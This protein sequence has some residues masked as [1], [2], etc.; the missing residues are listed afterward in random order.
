MAAKEELLEKLRQEKEQPRA[1]AKD[2][3]AEW[4]EAIAQLFSQLYKWLADPEAKH[5]LMVF[6]SS[7]TVREEDLLGEYDAPAFKIN[8][9]NGEAVYVVP[10]ARMV[11]GA[12]G[13]VDLECMPRRLT[14][15]R[16]EPTR[17]KLGRLPRDGGGWTFQDLTES[18]FWE[19]LSELL[20]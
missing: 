13:R 18:S 6:K 8:T 12:L 5:L 2:I 9:P 17:W 1:K 15:V 16:V 11:V 20:S 3:L 4:Q 7:T 19:A 10:K 14:L